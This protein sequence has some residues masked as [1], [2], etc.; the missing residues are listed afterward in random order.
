MSP[1]PTI[2]SPSSSVPRRLKRKRAPALRFDERFGAAFYDEIPAKPGV[3]RFEKEDGT[4]LYVGKAKNLRR[5]LSQYRNAKRRKKSMKMRTIVA[6]A[7]RLTFET[8]TSESEA[9]LLENRWIQEHRPPL[10][11]SGAF[12]FLY[13]LIGLRLEGSILTLVTTTQPEA[14]ADR[15]FEWH[16][17]FRSRFWVKEAFYAFQ[18]LLTFVGHPQNKNREPRVKYARLCV[19]RGI[20]A[21]WT[22]PLSSFFRGDSDE[23]LELLL[24][25][26]LENAGARKRPRWIQQRLNLLRNFWSEEARRLREAR[27]LANFLEYPVPQK[28]RDP[29][30]LRAKAR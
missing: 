7:A 17:A 13:P 29:L 12:S 18:E 15:G 14:F 4:I 10:N 20:P 26:L 25:E 2:R 6:G 28:E 16:G 21:H 3:Y 27:T 9:L 8:C 11:V 5:R 19:L 23:I 24:L 30:F 22:A 1:T